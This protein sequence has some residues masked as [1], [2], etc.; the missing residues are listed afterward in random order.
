M[1]LWLIP[2]A[3][4]IL[5]VSSGCEAPASYTDRPMTPYDSDTAYRV[6]EQPSGFTLFVRQAR[7]QFV[8]N[9]AIQAS[10]AQAI[11]SL[12]HEIAERRGHK[13]EF[14]N[15]HARMSFGRNGV[16]GI[17]TCTA[18]VPVTWADREE[19]ERSLALS[20]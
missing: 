16:N 8:L 13:I 5:A 18:M 10:C 15:E 19:A 4:L 3:F 17:S 2:T 6:D 20:P 12:A 9:D 11:R 1:R 7:Y 14:D